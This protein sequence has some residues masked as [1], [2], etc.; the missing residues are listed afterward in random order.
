M[1]ADGTQLS[2]CF[3][4]LFPVSELSFHSL[5]HASQRGEIA[6]MEAEPSRQLPNPLDRIQ[7]RAVRRQVTQHELRFLLHPPLGMQLGMV[8]LGVI[9]NHD[10]PASSPATAVAQL[11][12]KVPGSHR[13]KAVGFALEEKLSISQTDGAKIADALA[14]WMVKNHWVVHLGRNPHSGARTVLLKMDFI[15][16]PQINRGVSCQSAEFFYA[17]L[18]LAGQLERLEGAAC[19]GESPVGETTSGTDAPLTPRRTCAPSSGRGFCHP[20]RRRLLLQTR[21]EFVLKRFQPELFESNSSVKD[22]QG[23]LLRSIRPSHPFQNDGPNSPLCV[24]RH[25]AHRLLR[26]N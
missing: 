14:S 24:G 18:V 8:I 16:R 15:N 23:A 6:I 1:L 17:W 4:G 22:D 13:V 19:A 3:I 11:A 12:Q 9:G 10:H 5:Q 21:L 26:G 25:R 20:K 2:K 7:I